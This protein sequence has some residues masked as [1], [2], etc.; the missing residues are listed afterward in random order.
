MIMAKR[1]PAKKG[2]RSRYQGGPEDIVSKSYGLQ[3]TPSSAQVEEAHTQAAEKSGYGHPTSSFSVTRAGQTKHYTVKTGF[4][5]F[6]QS[7][8]KAQNLM[9]VTEVIETGIQSKDVAPIIKY[10]DMKVPEIARA[11]AVSPSTVSRW[12]ADS[13]IGI[14]GSNQFFKIDEVIRKGVA[15]FGNLEGLKGWL[16]TPNV[17]LGNGVPAN[18]ITSQIG[19]ALVDE[20]LDALH[21]GNVM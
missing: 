20:A 6:I 5:Y 13:S 19:V 17:A 16:Q 9:R 8:R 11:A 2:G 4:G 15:L 12:R 18:L 7:L 3:N 1:K 10:L 21:Y 14:S